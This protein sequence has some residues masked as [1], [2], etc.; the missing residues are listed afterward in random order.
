MPRYVVLVNLTEQG[1]KTI[2]DLPKRVQAAREAIEK[3]GGK[4]VD[5]NLTLGQYDADVILEAPDDSTVATV[6]LAV[7]KLANARTTTL[8]A[9][10]EAEAA[11]IVEKIPS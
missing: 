9:F 3:V 7:G 6:L 1:L 4:M 5:W 2:K 8:K 10:T 11:K